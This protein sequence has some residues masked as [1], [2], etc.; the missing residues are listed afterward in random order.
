MLPFHF[1]KDLYTRFAWNSFNLLPAVFCTHLVYQLIQGWR[2]FRQGD[3]Q[4]VL[5]HHITGPLRNVT[6]ITAHSK[7]STDYH[8]PFLKQLHA[9]SAFNILYPP[10][11]WSAPGPP[12][13]N[14]VFYICPFWTAV[15]LSMTK[16]FQDAVC[17]LWLSA[18]YFWGSLHCIDFHSYMMSCI[19]WAWTFTY[20]QMVVISTSA[21]LRCFLI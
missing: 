13:R 2:L 7:D 3:L 12:I 15:M 21:P 1:Y 14:H 6:P 11:I 5:H 19:S 18:L 16:V 20:Q 9:Q 8:S 4:C 10:P 17:G